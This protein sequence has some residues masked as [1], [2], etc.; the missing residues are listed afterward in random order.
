MGITYD[1]RGFIDINEHC[2]IPNKPHIYAIGDCVRG[3]MLAHKAEEEGM[4]VAEHI[5]GGTC[6]LNYEA[7]PGVVYTYP[8]MA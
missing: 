8:E 6:H 1:K 2:Q 5:S 4:Y 7:I 3:P